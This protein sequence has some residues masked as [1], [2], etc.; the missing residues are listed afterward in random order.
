MEPMFMLGVCV[1]VCVCVL[2][3]RATETVCLKPTSIITNTATANHTL[4]KRAGRLHGARE[5]PGLVA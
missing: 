1:C 3:V 4:M 5:R 2:K